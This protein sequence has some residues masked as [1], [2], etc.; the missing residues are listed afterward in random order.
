MM[1]MYLYLIS[2]ILYYYSVECSSQ[3]YFPPQIVFSPDG[4]KTIIAIDEI[5]QRAYISTG[6]E[7]AFV[8]KHFPYAIPDSPQS[9]YYVQL[10]VV[11]PSN[12]CAYGTYW[13]YGGNIYNSFPSDWVNGTSFEIKNYMKFTYNMIHSNDSSIDE[14]YWYSDVTCKVQTGETYPCEEIY[15]KK[16]TQIPLRLS[17]VV[18]Q[19][20]NIVKATY[21]Y[22][23][24]SMGKPDDK[25]FNSLPKNWSF[26][27]QDT[28]LGLLHYPQTAKVNLNESVE[29][30]IWLPTPPHR[31]NGNDT[32]IIQWKLRECTDCFTW[33][34]KQLSFNTEN[35][36]ERQILKITR[37]K[38]GSQTNLVPVFNGG[39]FD[40]A[41]AEVYSII[42]Q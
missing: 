9:K 16:N 42:I 8:M 17:R 23:I 38:D 7:T 11:H 35:F 4:G 5:N 29:V 14:D 32:V 19:G 36:Q 27:C 39:G 25:Y 1:K 33:T 2:F 21:P 12:W 13:K 10:L 26:I 41:L 34:P 30:E 20:W 37:V 24:I 28:M 22:T 18:R 15:F 6:G 40:N 31:I 3:P